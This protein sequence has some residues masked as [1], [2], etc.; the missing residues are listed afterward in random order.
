MTNAMRNAL[1]ALAARRGQ[2]GAPPG[3]IRIDMGLTDQ[4]EFR[5]TL[6]DN[7]VGV[8]SAAVEHL[9]EAFYTTKPAGQGTGLGLFVCR[10]IVE[11]WGGRVSLTS[12]E[13]SGACWTLTLPATR[14]ST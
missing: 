4:E 6:E 1:D 10:D 2:P 5:L 14:I 12:A 3:L 8:G 7:G 9:F 13:P 11:E